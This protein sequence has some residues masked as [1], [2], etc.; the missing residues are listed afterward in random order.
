VKY[1][2]IHD[3]GRIVTEA[4]AKNR[5]VQRR[6]IVLRLKRMLLLVPACTAF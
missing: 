6:P 2:I 5:A 4:G 3:F 1:K